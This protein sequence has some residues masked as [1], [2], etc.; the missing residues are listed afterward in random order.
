MESFYKIYLKISE[1]ATHF[2]SHILEVSPLRLCI[3]HRD[4]ILFSLVEAPEVSV[5]HDFVC[6]IT[7]E[8][9]GEAL[10]DPPQN[11]NGALEAIRIR[12]KLNFQKLLK[13]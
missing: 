9:P 10:S 7:T 13:T 6:A 11:L 3:G 2:F 12:V 4:S 8:I 1:F 5:C